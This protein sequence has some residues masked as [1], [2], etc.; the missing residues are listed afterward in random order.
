MPGML[1]FFENAILNDAAPVIGIENGKWIVHICIGQIDGAF[2]F[3]LTIFPLA[4][5]HGIDGLTNLIAS[6]CV[7]G[8]FVVPIAI[9]TGQRFYPDQFGP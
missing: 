4:H 9:I 5:D 2:D 6:M 1:A 8:V 3:G 7:L